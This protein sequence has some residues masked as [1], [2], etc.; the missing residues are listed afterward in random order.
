MFTCF[1]R[2]RCSFWILLLA[3]L[4]FLTSEDWHWPRHWSWAFCCFFSM[5]CTQASLH[6]VPSRHQHLVQL[7]QV[8]LIHA[9][10]ENVCSVLSLS[11]AIHS[12]GFQHFIFANNFKNCIYRCDLSQSSRVRYV[13]GTFDIFC[14]SVLIFPGLSSSIHTPFSS[15]G[16]LSLVNGSLIYQIA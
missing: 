3:S 1:L 9:W 4:L 13:T 12:L 2:P 5:L 6:E 14:V 10:A 7:S 16:I 11:E 8:V 15:L